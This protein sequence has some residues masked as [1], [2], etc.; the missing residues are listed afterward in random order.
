[1]QCLA[2]EE[3]HIALM[4]R[5]DCQKGD[6][7]AVTWS[8]AQVGLSAGML[9]GFT[10]HC[11][12][13]AWAAATCWRPSSLRRPLGAEC[14]LLLEGCCGAYQ[15]PAIYSTQPCSSCRNIYSSG[16]FAAT[17]H[18]VL[19]VTHTHHICCVQ[20]EGRKVVG[21]LSSLLVLPI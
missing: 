18:T 3:S 1:M 11:A 5:G 4:T 17:G 2:C 20:G 8:S 19:S 6:Q 10:S 12:S 14:Q 15:S 13:L 21:L 9:V 16:V 7:G